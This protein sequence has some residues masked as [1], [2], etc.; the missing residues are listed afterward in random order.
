MTITTLI[1]ESLRNRTR[2]IKVIVRRISSQNKN[3]SVIRFALQWNSSLKVM[4]YALRRSIEQK[5]DDVSKKFLSILAKR[6]G[7]L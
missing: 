7:T 3:F 4:N 5:I 1:S 2:E 6:V